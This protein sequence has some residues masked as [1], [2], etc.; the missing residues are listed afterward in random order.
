MADKYGPIVETQNINDILE[1][2]FGVGSPIQTSALTSCIVVVG[3]VTSQEK[4]LGI[5][6]VL[7]GSGGG[8][9]DNAAAD[10]VGEILDEQ[11]V[12]RN[13]ACMVGQVDFWGP[14][15]PPG[16]DQLIK[17]LDNPDASRKIKTADDKAIK[18]T[19]DKS[20]KYGFKVATV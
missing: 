20:A 7:F 1:Q 8:A 3:R 5:H 15:Q 9:F 2:Q 13:Q 16:Y 11:K 17:V 12:P 6:L 18:V 19:F 4:V 14:G 10:R